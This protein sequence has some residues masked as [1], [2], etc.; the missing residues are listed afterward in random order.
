[1]G[2]HS[3]DDDGAEELCLR[4]GGLSFAKVAATPTPS[5][6]AAPPTAAGGFMAAWT[7]GSGANLRTAAAAPRVRRE[8][9]HKYDRDAL[10]K[11]RDRCKALPE[12]ADAAALE[13]LL[14]FTDDDDE[15]IADD[16]GVDDDA[17][18]WRSKPAQQANKTQNKEAQQ[19]KPQTS[20]Q[21]PLPTKIVKAESPWQPGKATTGQDRLL[22]TVKGILNKL[23]PE[24]FERLFEQLIDSGI[25]T[26]PLLKVTISQIFEKAVAEPTFCELYAE[27]CVRLQEVLPEFPPL[28]GESKPMTFRRVLLN[29]CQEEFEGTAALRAK[30]SSVTAGERVY[31]ERRVKVRTLGNIR[32]I[33]ELY[34]KRMVQEKIIHVCIGDL[35]GATEK[36]PE[37]DNIEAL[38]QLLTIAGKML[39]ESQRAAPQMEGVYARLK[40]IS[41]DRGLAARFRFLCRD[42]LDLCNNGWVPRRE[43]LKAKKL[44]EVHREG[45]DALGVGVAS[46]GLQH[47]VPVDNDDELFPAFKSDPDGWEVVT[48]KKNKSADG[49][50]S[51]AFIGEYIPPP[52]PVAKS[53]MAPKPAK[54]AKKLSLEEVEQKTKSMLDEYVVVGDVAEA[55]L[56]VQE[57]YAPEHAERISAMLYDR[58][59]EDSKEKTTELLAKLASE[60]VGKKAIAASS[61]KAATCELFKGLDDLAI[62]VPMTPKLVGSIVGELAAKKLFPLSWLAEACEPVEDFEVKR[63]V[64]AEILLSVKKALGESS[65]MEIVRS[66]NFDA[67]SF[68]TD[69]EEEKEGEKL[70]TFLKGKGLTC[71]LSP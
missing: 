39:S 21:G 8:P 52:A 28:E 6:S 41:S 12:N 5:S 14:I 66:D 27:L 57:L 16:R 51:S 29:T 65:L 56:C 20:S 23:T 46:M 17:R 11:I 68:L 47:S 60:L 38:C 63:K 32:L 31:E 43:E 53:E 4:P 2:A 69:E 25:T 1:M 34:K 19:S 49:K 3:T 50:I 15:R 22:R 30:L 7:R 36:L 10:L 13:G 33:A 58:S 70:S 42:V 61:F 44:D 35:L 67:S 62:D 54:P 26:A 40:Q 59:I 71:V 45:A 18:D 55:L 9:E 64:C 48:S 37:E 24:K